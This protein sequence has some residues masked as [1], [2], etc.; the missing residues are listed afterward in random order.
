MNFPLDII[1]I[2]FV[3]IAGEQR[4]GLAARCDA[5]GGRR[6]RIQI[7]NAA[8]APGSVSGMTPENDDVLR[9]ALCETLPCSIGHVPLA[10]RNAKCGPKPWA[11]AIS[12]IE[13]F[14][15]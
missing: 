15:G 5:D 7:E 4:R 2:D 9:S 3:H 12:E 10:F 11:T 13:S 1:E 14:H 6:S 8:L